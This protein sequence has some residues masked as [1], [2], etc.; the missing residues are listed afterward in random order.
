M[1]L[2]IFQGVVTLAT[3]NVTCVSNR[4][5]GFRSSQNNEV[6]SAAGIKA[7]NQHSSPIKNNPGKPNGSDVASVSP[8]V[9]NRNRGENDINNSPI[10]EVPEHNRTGSTSGKSN[11]TSANHVKSLQNDA[12][13][14]SNQINKSAESC[15]TVVDGLLRTSPDGSDRT[16]PILESNTSLNKKSSNWLTL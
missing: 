10:V 5:A 3:T 14:D 6:K 9:S 11:M 8:N 13:T 7:S 16:S 4:A 1:F 2:I 15:N 12:S